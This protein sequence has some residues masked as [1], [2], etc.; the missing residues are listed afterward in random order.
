MCTEPDRSWVGAVTAAAIEPD[1]TAGRSHLGWHA[2]GRA[3]SGRD[4]G[5]PHPRRGLDR[6]TIRT[7]PERVARLGDLSTG[8]L[9][10]DQLPSLP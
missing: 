3:A 2:L 6:W 5:V 10:H 7:A 4:I 1:L 8:V 9:D